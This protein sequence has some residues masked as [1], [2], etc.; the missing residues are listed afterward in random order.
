METVFF[1][2][3]FYGETGPLLCFA[4]RKPRKTS[5]CQAKQFSSRAYIV[6]PIHVHQPSCLNPPGYLRAYQS[7]IYLSGKNCQLLTLKLGRTCSQIYS[8]NEARQVELQLQHL[9]SP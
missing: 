1:P 8:P 4:L 2:V 6:L 7:I 3:G 9:N 5:S